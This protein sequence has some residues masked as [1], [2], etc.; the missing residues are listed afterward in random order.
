MALLQNGSLFSAE[1]ITRIGGSDFASTVVPWGRGGTNQNFFFSDALF[2]AAYGIPTEYSMPAAW[3][4]P[5]EEGGMTAT[6]TVIT[7]T[8]GVQPTSDMKKG[9]GITAVG[10]SAV[11]GSG[12]IKSAS[13][14]VG[15]SSL[16]ALA[17]AGHALTGSGGVSA[18]Y[19]VGLKQL[20]TTNILGGGRIKA[21]ADLTGTAAL[22]SDTSRI[23]G[24]GDVHA[25]GLN[26][27]IPVAAHLA[28]SGGSKS[29]TNLTGTAPLTASGGHALTGSGN[30][31]YADLLAVVQLASSHIAGGGGIT[32]AGL[33]FTMFLTAHLVGSGYI[34]S[35]TALKGVASISAG[36]LGSGR[37]SQAD[38]EMGLYIAA[39]LSGHGDLIDT[40]NLTGAAWMNAAI[41]IGALPSAKDNA[42]AVL[43]ALAAAYNVPGT[44]GQKINSAASSGDPWSTDL[45]GGYSGTQ[46]G[47]LLTELATQL[48]LDAVAAKTSLIPAQPASVGSEMTLT[49]AYDAAKTA[50]AAGA[51]MTLTPTE[52]LALIGAVEY[53]RH[54]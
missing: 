41:R 21:T 11:S 16:L 42:D 32:N 49:P 26:M 31:T 18:A 23:A 3:V 53:P 50:A 45:P 9:G 48:S 6:G 25:A 47:K 15:I 34:K 36:L 37:V 2:S 20:A 39:L 44:I 14:M 8:G 29:T 24:T 17:S 51:A 30:L 12:D 35:T 38:L 33:G 54:Y 13:N 22:T 7:A 43:G 19:L 4:M 10:A 46:A 40:S 1:P 28:G 5:I 27:G 52:R